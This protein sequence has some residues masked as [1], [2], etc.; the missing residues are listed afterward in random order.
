MPALKNSKQN[1][2]RPSEMKIYA[3]FIWFPQENLHYDYFTFE[4]FKLHVERVTFISQNVQVSV[5]L[6]QVFEILLTIF[7]TI[8]HCVN[9]FAIVLSRFLFFNFHC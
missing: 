7:Y 6:S 9:I 2:R 1:I 8:L 3:F 5:F 4:D